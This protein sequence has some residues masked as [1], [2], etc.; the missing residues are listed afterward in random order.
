MAPRVVLPES[1]I[2]LQRHRRRMLLLWSAVTVCILLLGGSIALLWLPQWR[3][4]AVS[5]TGTQTLTPSAIATVAYADLSGRYGYII[6]KNNVLVYP[7][8]KI[9]A[10]VLRQFPVLQTV[11]VGIENFHTLRV[12]VV[13]RTPV[14][15]YCGSE[16]ASNTPCYLLDQNG[17]VYAPALQNSESAYVSYFGSTTQGALPWQY[18]SPEQFQSLL[19]L[20]QAVNGVAKTDTVHSVS[21]DSLGEVHMMFGSGFT[22]L[23]MLSQNPGDVLHSFS[24][25]LTSDPFTTHALSAVEYLDMRFGDR[26]Y[27][28]LK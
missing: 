22:L 4:T 19:A 24:L 18:L 7:K 9:S 15:Q 12:G 6:P 21:V 20:T 25:A 26:L 14:A 23:F 28:K 3:I 27:Y 5:I 13:E 10:D 17:M 1:R 2:R 16:A 11:S 8:Q